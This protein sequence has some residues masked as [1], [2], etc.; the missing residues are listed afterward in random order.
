M[1]HNPQKYGEQL[2]ALLR[3]LA[4]A[5]GIVTQ[6]ETS[7][8]KLLKKEFGEGNE[9]Q[10]EFDPEALKSVVENSYEAEELLELLLMVSLSD[11][12]TT[13]PEWHLIQEVAQIL[14]VS[15]ERL[16]ELRSETVLAVD[17]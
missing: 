6:E 9:G 5:D 7:W 10:V 13:P 12:Q 2:N 1:S 4:E 14:G 17:P 16:E 8:L 3:K 11:G 15:A